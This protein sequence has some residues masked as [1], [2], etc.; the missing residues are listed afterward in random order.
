MLVV[1][2]ACINMP[3][4]GPPAEWFPLKRELTVDDLR[5]FRSSFTPALSGDYSV[6]LKFQQPIEVQEIRDLVNRATASVGIDGALAGFDFEWRLL[7]GDKPLARGTG[8]QGAMGIIDRGSDG[9]GGGTLKSR[10]LAFGKFSAEA[11]R[12]YTIEF[13]AG[14]A[15]ASVIRVKPQL[16]IMLD[17]T[18]GR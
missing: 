4:S 10:A 3:G 8:R 14:P 16:E 15:M 18:S 7:D 1:V 11:N 13:E 2:S 6:T 9:L 5:G 17:P 12:L